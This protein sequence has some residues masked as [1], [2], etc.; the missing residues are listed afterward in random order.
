M[1]SVTYSVWLNIETE[2][3]DLTWSSVGENR[4]QFSQKN[5]KMTENL[6]KICVRQTLMIDIV[7][8]EY[9]SVTSRKAQ[10]MKIV[11]PRLPNTS[12]IIE[13][14][15]LTYLSSTDLISICKKFIFYDTQ[16]IH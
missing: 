4:S 9:Y 2:F 10:H 1:E 13:Y 11:N 3:I 8:P 6:L 14:I 12:Q 5:L 16:C 7:K 15:F